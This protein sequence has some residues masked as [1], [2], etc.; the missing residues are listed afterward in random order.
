MGAVLYHEGRF[1]PQTLDWSKLI[2]LLGPAAACLARYDG[3]LAAIPNPDLLLS[4]LTTQEAVLSSGIEGS[5]ATMQEVLEFE[6]GQEAASPEKRDDIFEV[7][8]YR[9]AI[10]IAEEMLVK[11]PLSNRVMSE[12]HRI[13]LSGVRGKDKSPG[14]FRRRQNWIGTPGC[15]IKDAFFVPISMDKLPGALSTWERFIHTKQPGLY[16][17]PSCTRNLRHCIHMKMAMGD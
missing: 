10:R 11:L 7:L 5:Q 6:A 8:N 15:K 12:A 16:S 17:L 1:P 13:L 3:M 2:P 14:N 9:K 4:P